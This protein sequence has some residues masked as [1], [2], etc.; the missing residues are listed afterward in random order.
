[1]TGI[2]RSERQTKRGSQAC[3]GAIVVTQLR[4]NSWKHQT[5]IQR[6]AIAFARALVR[7]K[8]EQSIFE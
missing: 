1:M 8:E 7:T 4:R 2:D 6:S 3:G 5:V